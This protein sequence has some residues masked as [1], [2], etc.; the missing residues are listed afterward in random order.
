MLKFNYTKDN[1]DVSERYALIVQ[2][3]SPLD[4]MMDLSSLSESE[5]NKVET[6]WNEYKLLHEALLERFSFSKYM[7]TFKPKGISDREV[8]WVLDT[9]QSDLTFGSKVKVGDK[10]MIGEDKVTIN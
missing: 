7:K 10:A 5:R 3:N 4:L 6:E 1:G 8:V 9:P 2:Q